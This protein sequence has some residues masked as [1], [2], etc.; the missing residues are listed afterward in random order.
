M[1]A[2]RES[3]L[4]KSI[5]EIYK[6]SI[7]CESKKTKKGQGIEKKTSQPILTSPNK[8]TKARTSNE[9]A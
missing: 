9:K 1:P 2:R 5:L 6:T 8:Q 7:S 3:F 4:N